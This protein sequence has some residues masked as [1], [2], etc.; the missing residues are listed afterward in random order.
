MNCEENLYFQKMKCMFV[1]TLKYTS[2]WMSC[3]NISQCYVA[4]WNA[5]WEKIMW[6]HISMLITQKSSS[7][8]STFSNKKI[9]TESWWVTFTQ[10]ILKTKISVLTFSS[11]WVEDWKHTT[12]NSIWYFEQVSLSLC[13]YE[14]LCVCCV[15]CMCVWKSKRKKDTETECG[16]ECMYMNENQR[17]NVFC[18]GYLSQSTTFW[19]ADFFFPRISE[20]NSVN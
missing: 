1:K 5:R 3:G 16:S 4:T 10:S 13:V 18:Y 12:D 8:Q 7:E 17:E 6:Q 20:K 15:L 11:A 9:V 14:C 2:S 19:T